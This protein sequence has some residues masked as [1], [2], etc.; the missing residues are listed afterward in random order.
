MHY[1]DTPPTLSRIPS[2]MLAWS[3]TVRCSPRNA[4]RKNGVIPSAAVVHMP[5]TPPPRFPPT[6]LPP[7]PSKTPRSHSWFKHKILSYSVTLHVPSLLATEKAKCARAVTALRACARERDT[8]QAK[9]GEA[10][11]ERKEAKATVDVSVYPC[12]LSVHVFPCS[13]EVVWSPWSV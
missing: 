3:T 8:A 10:A 9:G 1:G 13:L 7:P 12:G 5:R 11:L 2:L 4:I 6:P